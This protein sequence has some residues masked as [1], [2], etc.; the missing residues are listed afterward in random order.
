MDSLEA[1]KTELKISRLGTF[2]V[3]KYLISGTVYSQS[4]TVLLHQCEFD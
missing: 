2:N 3:V 4:I 1:K